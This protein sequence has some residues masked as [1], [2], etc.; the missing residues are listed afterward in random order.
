M[1]YCRSKLRAAYNSQGNYDRDV[2]AAGTIRND[3]VCSDRDTTKKL[4]H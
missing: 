4:H 2:T 1:D 3:P